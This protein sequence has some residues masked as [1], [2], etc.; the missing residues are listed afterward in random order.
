ML[1]TND[2]RLLILRHLYIELTQLRH[3]D[4][5]I[6]L[7]GIRRRL[8]FQAIKLRIQCKWLLRLLDYGLSNHLHKPRHVNPILKAL[9][10]LAM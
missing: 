6:V 4:I 3:D 8:I 2:L 7:F 5:P 10:V 9:R 1:S